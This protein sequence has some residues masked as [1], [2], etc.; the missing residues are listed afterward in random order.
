MSVII[1]HVPKNT[2]DSPKKRNII[3]VQVKTIVRKEENIELSKPVKKDLAVI[4]KT[5]KPMK[6]V[7]T[8][9][10]KVKVERKPISKPVKNARAVQGVSE[11]S[12]APGSTA[13]SV[14]L[15]NTLMTKDEGIR[16]KKDEIDELEKDLSTEAQLIRNTLQAPQY[17]DEALDAGLEG[18]FIIEVF[19]GAD[20]RVLDVDLGKTIGYG[21]DDRIIAAIENAR[22][23]PRK[24]RGGSPLKGWTEIRFQLEIP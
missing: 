12:V 14:P 8:K 11:K 19:V 6:K 18:T 22:F 13:F 20:G 2:K 17:T 7:K 9:K 10:D 23:T 4:K 24:D 15:G 21:M 5:K 1:Q 3:A 16:L